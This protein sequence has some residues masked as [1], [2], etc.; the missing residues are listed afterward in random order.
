[1]GLNPKL[2]IIDNHDSFTFNLVE[3]CRRSGGY[4]IDVAFPEQVSQK[5]WEEAD[6]VILSPGPGLPKESKGLLHMLSS[7]L[8]LK[9][10]FGICLGMQALAVITG[11]SLIQMSNPKHGYASHIRNYDKSDLLYKNVKCPIKVGRYHSWQINQDSLNDVW[12]PT[13]YTNS[14]VLMS[15]SHSKLPVWA[16]Q[17]HPESYITEQG[18]RI[19]DN[20]LSF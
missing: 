3:S 13:A 15:M 1:M 5:T 16:V 17:Y 4:E 7:F 10:V 19:I 11:N 6:R 8:D 18:D 14:N 20:F 12:V 9:P 2:L